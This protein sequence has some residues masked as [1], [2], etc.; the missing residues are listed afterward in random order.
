M[1][2]F[3]GSAH[4]RAQLESIAAQSVPPV[5]L[6]VFDD[7]STDGTYSLIADFASEA[8]FPVHLH[9]NPTT[10][11]V[12]ANFEA[13]IAACTGELIALCDQDD[14]WMPRKLESLASALTAAPDADIACSDATLIAPDGELLGYTAHQW[15]SRASVKE[16]L[17]AP[18]VLLTIL[19]DR[20]VPGAAML[21]RSRLRDIAC[22]FPH[23]T[24][25]R[26]GL[27]HDGWL[28][29]VAAA[30]GGFTVVDEP[31]F[32]YR[33]HEAQQTG[34]RGTVTAEGVVRRKPRTQ[35]APALDRRR[36]LAAEATALASLERE[37]TARTG[38][39]PLESGRWLRTRREHLQRRS[40]LLEMP[41]SLRL[42]G[43]IRELTKGGYRRH[44][45]GLKSVLRDLTARVA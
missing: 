37:L 22:P 39:L 7:G 24:L 38:S 34:M 16:Q 25:E 4:L 31:L 29:L 2:T 9:Q 13:A 32:L 27:L 19:R 6:V 42:P 33:Q 12:T 20:L 30:S 36:L 10:L 15:A 45:A 41:R 28:S 14:I 18:S 43:V 35:R 17:E 44:S 5:E 40:E 8:A 23:D 3:N 1:C 11:G 26:L 21:I